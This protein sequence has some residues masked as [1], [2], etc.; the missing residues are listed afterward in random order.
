MGGGFSRIAHACCLDCSLSKVNK[1]QAADENARFQF[2]VQIEHV[3]AVCSIDLQRRY[4]VTI[5]GTE[6]SALISN[7]H[8]VQHSSLCQIVE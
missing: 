7:G 5:R 8:Q 6:L 4:T 3:L 2:G 1:V